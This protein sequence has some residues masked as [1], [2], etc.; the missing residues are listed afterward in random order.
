VTKLEIVIADDHPV[1]RG[2]LRYLIDAQPDMRVV[3][4]AADG[5][6]ALEKVLDLAPHV[7]LI[8]VSM[9]LISGAEL[10]ERLRAQ[11]P[12]VKVLALSAHEQRGYM[13]QM[14]AAGAVGYVVKRAAAEELTG[15]IR[16]VA[17]GGAYFY[18]S[19]ANATPPAVRPRSLRMNGPSSELSEREAQVLRSIARGHPLKEI[20]AELVVSVRTVETYKVRAMEKLALESRADIIRVAVERGWLGGN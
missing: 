16:C 7:A 20:A 9:P 8:D 3:G 5:A 13:Q 10:T 11:R 1:V 2:G 4:E 15:A 14:I 17:G 12:M 18:P 6:E 19:M